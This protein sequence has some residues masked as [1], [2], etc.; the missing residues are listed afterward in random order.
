[1]PNDN[2]R[3]QQTERR[4]RAAYRLILSW[5][6]KPELQA[7]FAIPKPASAA[8]NNMSETAIPDKNIPPKTIG[9]ELG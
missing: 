4:L 2:T 8:T 1:M 7:T 6:V 5:P 9:R 3:N